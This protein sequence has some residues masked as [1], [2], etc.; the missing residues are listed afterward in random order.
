MRTFIPTNRFADTSSSLHGRGRLPRA[1]RL[2]RPREIS[3][4]VSRYP[5]TVSPSSGGSVQLREAYGNVEGERRSLP[6]T[7]RVPL[8]SSLV[9]CHSP[10]LFLASGDPAV[11]V[12]GFNASGL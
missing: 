3:R 7:K 10:S 9:Q 4:R 6:F 5:H 2:M 11:I 12:L 1:Q 8:A